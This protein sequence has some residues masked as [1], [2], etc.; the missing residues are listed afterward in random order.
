MKEIVKFS[1]GT[2]AIRRKRFSFDPFGIV[3]QYQDL[4]TGY[5][6]VWRNTSD[7]F[8]KDCKGTMKRVLEVHNPEVGVPVTQAEIDAALK[9]EAEAE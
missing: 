1:D 5:L 9:A 7:K 8:F 3:Y 2:Y 6:F 4:D